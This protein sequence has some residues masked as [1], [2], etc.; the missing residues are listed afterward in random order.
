MKPFEFPIVTLTLF[1]VVGIA[2]GTFLAIPLHISILISGLLL[3]S[4]FLVYLITKNTFKQTLWFGLLAFT[5][6]LS[7]GVLTVNFH[8]HLNYKNHYLHH[9]DITKNQEAILYFSISEVLKPN[10][11]NNRYVA[12]LITINNQNV[13]GKVLL[14][15]SKDSI[16]PSFQVDD[17]LLLKGH[18]QAINGPLNPNQ[19]NYKRY[20][21]NQYIYAQIYSDYSSIFS[22]S[23]TK[24]S[25]F[26][27]ADLVREAIKQNLKRY[28]FS[29]DE[30]AVIN[31]LL[32]GQRQDISTALKEDYTK[33]GAM[34][35]LA[36]SGLHVGIILLVLNVMLK[37]VTY[38]KN[39]RAIKISI[40]LLLLW[41]YGFIAGLSP[42]VLRAVTMFSIVAVSMNFK[43][44]TNI[45]NTLAISALVLLLFKPLLLFEIGFQLSY[46]AV[47][48]IVSI[49]PLLFQIVKTK[50]WLINKFSELI[51]VSLAAQLGI[52]P[53]SLFY[54]HQFPGLFLV[55]NVVIIPLLGLILG[56]GLLVFMLALL[57][58]PN[59]FVFDVYGNLIRLMNAFFKWIAQQEAFIINDISI[60]WFLV[61]SIYIVIITSS[62]LLLERHRRQLTIVLISICVFQLT[63]LG[64]KFVHE[65]TNE[66]IVFHKNK[67]TI[68]GQKQGTKL[69]VFHSLEPLSK[70]SE[71][72]ITNYMVGNFIKKTT[73][74][75]L[76]NGFYF[77]NK[78]L[79]LVDS[80]SVYQTKLLKP[81]YVLLCQ[82]PKINLNR[83]ID[84]LNPKL[85]IADGSNYSSYIKRWEATCRKRKLPF[86][87]TGK[88][89]AFIIK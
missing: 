7:V 31:A 24:H 26:G 64:T 41:S 56:Y 1:L 82:S 65:S 67:Q 3:S 15:V 71:P 33:A 39:G 36:I 37:P 81:D 60:N 72:N 59:G 11:F 2:A 47:I 73:E 43:R 85:I 50:Y 27:Y 87:Q 88:K 78:S 48:G 61:V 29:T 77:N 10:T 74:S 57:Q 28:N 25:I 23:K 58:V 63:L 19:F 49:Q 80:S 20:L 18:M 6:M 45:Y 4:L 16:K 52:F 44:P 30:L 84:S 12:K 8:N 17:K 38:F 79:L 14:N 55:T 5:T 86:H 89:G 62:R 51:T 46:L 76:K 32:L 9:Y 35:I 42:S 53:L 66:L 34:H 54:F 75:P 69:Q 40:I 21:E 13:V 68:I 83:L 70:V 22:V